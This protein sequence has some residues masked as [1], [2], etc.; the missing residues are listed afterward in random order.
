MQ[1]EKRWTITDRFGNHIYLTQ[2]RWEH[3]IE[4]FNHPEMEF[5]EDAL[6]ETIRRGQRRQE[7]LNPQKYR[8]SM[9]FDHLV[10]FNTHI[11]AIVLF[12]FRGD[13]GEI[14]AN[15]YIVTAFQK[16]IG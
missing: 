9:T 3:I 4:P 7:P 13:V 10:D 5:Y 6:M 14:V 16:E 11:V 15:N 12:R 2:E 1:F 8:Y